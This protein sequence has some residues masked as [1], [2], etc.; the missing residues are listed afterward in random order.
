[1]IAINIK[2]IGSIIKVIAI[3][4]NNAI[5][6]ILN[7]FPAVLLAYF[8]ISS[9]SFAHLILNPLDVSGNCE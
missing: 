4:I 9:F 5:A 2:L 1:M 8:H 6:V 3:N 7:I